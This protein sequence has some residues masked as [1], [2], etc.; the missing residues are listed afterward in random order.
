MSDRTENN[1]KGVLLAAAVIALILPA[2]I[3]R[4]GNIYTHL[5]LNSYSENL[6]EMRPESITMLK[7]EACEYNRKI[8]EEQKKSPFSYRG[9]DASDEEYLK[10]AKWYAR[11]AIQ[12]IH[13]RAERIVNVLYGKL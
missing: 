9:S 2:F 5:E 11:N 12:I 4:A 8:R 6:S 7:N 3:D 13:A 10:G 1:I